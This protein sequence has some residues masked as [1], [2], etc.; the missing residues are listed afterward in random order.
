L[1]AASISFTDVAISTLPRPS[2][3]VGAAQWRP[4]ARIPQ[5]EPVRKRA[6]R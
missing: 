6:Q 4:F 5:T 1:A 2:Q 3:V